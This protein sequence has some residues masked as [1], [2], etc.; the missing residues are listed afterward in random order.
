MREALARAGYSLLLRLVTPL[1]LLRLWWRGR[2]VEPEGR[3]QP[4]TAS[5]SISTS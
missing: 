1:Y 3:P 4:T 2:A 5:A